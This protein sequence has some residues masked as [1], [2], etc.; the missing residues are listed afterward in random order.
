MIR[1]KIAAI[2]SLVVG[3]V[4]VTILSAGPASAAGVYDCSAAHSVC[5]YYN[6]GAYGYGAYFKQTTDL[7]TYA[8][9]TFKAGNN[10]SSGAGVEVKNHGAALDS[11]YNGYFVLY[12]NSNY[13]CS[14]ACQIFAPLAT[15]ADFSASLHNDNASGAFG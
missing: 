13:D 5:L 1:S 11:W 8:G 14:K 7:P 12:L 3:V 15:F 2:A 4:S 10:G 9:K 6:S